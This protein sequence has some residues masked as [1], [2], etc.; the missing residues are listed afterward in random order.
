M[1]SRER[2]IHALMHEA[3][4]RAPRDLWVAPAVEM[5]HADEVAEMRFRYPSDII[6]PEFRWPRG[7]RAKGDPGEVGEHTDAWGCIWQVFRRGMPG[8]VT[9]H[10]LADLAQIATYHPPWELLEKANLST[11]GR[12]CAATPRFV[13][14]WSDVRPFER[15]QLLHGPAATR[16]ELASPGRA[17]RDLLAM[18]HDFSCREIEMW[19]STDVDGVAFADNWGSTHSLVI[20]RQVWRD[21]FKPLYRRYCEILRLRDKFVFF[22][23]GGNVAEILEDLVE[24]GVDAVNVD[25]FLTDLDVLA[26]KL[27]GRITFWGEIDR[28]RILPFG[29]P[30]EVRTA[31]GRVRAALD[32]GRGGVIARCE[33]GPGVPF[34]NVAAVFEQWLAPMP[35]HAHAP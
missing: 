16:A 15:L 1:T 28:Q 4:D 18:L 31:V 14:A 13:L 27:R 21:L 34:R 9:G 12:S 11:V 7:V 24:I 19:A 33:W 35:V 6:R 30:G 32:Q 23:Y 17:L 2:V 26:E 8:E 10:P 20:P 25:L 3:V 29:T 5:F 22:R